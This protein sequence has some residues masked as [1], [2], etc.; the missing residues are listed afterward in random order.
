MPLFFSYL[1]Q[2][3]RR[4]FEG[5]SFDNN[6]NLFKIHLKNGKKVIMV[7]F[8]GYSTKPKV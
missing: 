8:I 6:I 7:D 4:Y 2:I 3:D 1:M 5:S